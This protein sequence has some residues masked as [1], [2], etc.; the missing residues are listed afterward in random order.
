MPSVLPDLRERLGAALFL[1]VAGPDGP[2]HRERIHFR[3]G[4]ALVRG[5]QPDHPGARRRVH[6][7]RRAAGVPAADAAPGRDARG[8]GALRL[9]RRHV[10]PAAPHQHVPR[11]HHVRGRPTTR[12]RRSTRSAGS[13][14]GSPATH[15]RRHAVRRLRPAP[16]RL[17]ARG[18]GGQLPARAPGLR[19]PAA[20]PGRAATSTSRRSPRS[21]A[22]LGVVDPPTTEA[23]LAEVL[24]AY[25]PE[26]RG[27]PRGAGGGA[28]RAAQAAAAAGRPRAVRRARGRRDRADA[29]VDPAAAAAALPAGLGAHRGAGAGRAGHRDDP[30]GDAPTRGTTVS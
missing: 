24:A 4:P 1:R 8:L 6:V 28:L 10:G 23:E 7:R 13:T 14:S 27:H 19:P 5:R 30:L 15:A 22:R 12:S 3:D 21:A 18:R 20:R 17:G 25:R 9:P 2:R 11:G 16:A 26:L 29:G